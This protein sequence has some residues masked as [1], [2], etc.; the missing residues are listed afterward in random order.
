MGLRETEQLAQ[1]SFFQF[2]CCGLIIGRLS[3]LLHNYVA[4][5]YNVVAADHQ[6]EKADTNGNEMFF[7][8]VISLRTSL[9]L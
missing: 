4:G 7:I 9:F 1:V 8:C 3:L 6:N 5:D 2:C